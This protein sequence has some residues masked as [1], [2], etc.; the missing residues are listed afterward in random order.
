[1]KSRDNILNKLRRQIVDQVALPEVLDGPWIQYDDPKSQFR[2]MVEFVGGSVTEVASPTEMLDHL[3]NFDEWRAAKRIFS[4]IPEVPGNVDLAAVEDAHDLENLDFVA[5][6]AQF[7]V[8]ENG[9][10]YLS[11]SDLRHRVIFF[12]TQ[13]LVLLVDQRDLVHNMHQ[14][15][16]QAV[17]PQP[18][19]GL[20]LSGPSKTA[21]IEQSLVIG[22]HGCRELQ[23]FLLN[24]PS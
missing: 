22:A 9:A 8:A 2:T 19:F 17:I 24:N 7:A 14:A 13:F 15:Y 11:D 3:G 6:R 1:M 21:D 12:I 23:V 20:F 5:Y 18:G 4:S 16:R 10:V